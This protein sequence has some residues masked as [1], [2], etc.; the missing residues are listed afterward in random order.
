MPFR[1]VIAVL[2][3]LAAQPAGSRR[4]HSSSSAIGA[5]PP[6]PVG[7]ARRLQGG[8]DDGPMIYWDLSKPYPVSDEEHPLAAPM[9][10][11]A[12]TEPDV[13][14][15]IALECGKVV[16]EY[17]DTGKDPESLFQLRSITKTWNGLLLGVAVREGLIDPQETLGEIWPD[18]QDWEGIRDAELRQ[19]ITVEQVLQMRGGFTMP[20]GYLQ[21]ALRDADPFIQ[22][23]RLGG[24]TF[25][26]TLG[27]W[28]ISE[29]LIDTYNYAMAGQLISYIIRE[30]TGMIPEE[31]AK[32]EVFPFLGITEDDYLWYQNWEDVSLGFHGLHLNV[33]SMSKL[34]MLYLQ[35]GMASP[36]KRIVE[37]SWIDASFA[38]PDDLADDEDPFGYLWW[39]GTDPVYCTYGFLGQMVCLNTETHRVIAISTESIDFL[40]AGGEGNV[41]DPAEA[42]PDEH[43]QIVN[44]FMFE[45]PDEPIVCEPYVAVADPTSAP[46][47]DDS[48]SSATTAPAPGDATTTPSVPAPSPTDTIDTTTGSSDAVAVAPCI[49][50]AVAAM[51]MTALL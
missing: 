1:V 16:A 21:E 45:E 14:G 46:A 48:S 30:R 50:A 4:F 20:D 23:H 19:S 7:V 28:N 49:A 26:D 22:K 33:P 8:D 44:L 41:T 2:L 43:M 27:Y 6:F 51:V 15:Y 42:I 11:I 37:Q 9:R 38:E 13:N 18:P 17:Y 25:E 36:D 47:P 10:A 35:G 29:E 34:G 24:R 40:F 12:E 5:V 39:L 3:F 32:Q 31:W